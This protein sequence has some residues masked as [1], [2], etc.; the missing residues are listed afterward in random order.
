MSSLLSAH[1]RIAISPETHFLVLSQR[2]SDPALSRYLDYDG[3]WKDWMASERFEH[4]GIDRD[5]VYKRI[6][7]G[8]AP[9][10]RNVFDACM[11]E[12]AAVTGKARWGEKTPY[13]FHY[14]D[15]LQRWYPACT[16]ILMVRDPRAVVA[17]NRRAPWGK[18]LPI[19]RIIREWM[20]SVR[21]YRKREQDPRVHLVKYEDLVRAPE[22]V[23]RA[24]CGSLKERYEP[25]MLSS[26]RRCTDRIRGREGWHR[27]Q[28]V[29]AQGQITSSRID[30]WKIELSA[31]QIDYID[32]VTH[33]YRQRLGYHGAKDRQFFGFMYYMTYYL[34]IIER[35]VVRKARKVLS[36]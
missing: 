15:T 17:S 7:E 25:R 16:V 12:Y 29:K 3:F 21:E 1:S 14:I 28:L 35:H 23:C 30:R 13:H 26:K 22:S 2:Y 34:C 8:G 36:R 24:L 32:T 31:K 33:Q 5:A 10:V 11:Q 19:C 6:Q 9:T 4:L 18:G 20:L 27:D